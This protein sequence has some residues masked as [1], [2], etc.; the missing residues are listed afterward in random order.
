M[1]AINNISVLY[2]ECV[3][4][5]STAENYG[6]PYTGLC[7]TAVLRNERLKEVI[8]MDKMDLWEKKSASE[9]NPAMTQLRQSICLLQPARLIICR[10]LDMISTYFSI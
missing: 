10:F 3:N 5:N 4:M 8:T 7:S 6:L 1:T 2:E 9:S